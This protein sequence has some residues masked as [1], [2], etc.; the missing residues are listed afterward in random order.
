[1]RLLNEYKE[2]EFAMEKYM[3]LFDEKDYA[4]GKLD[5]VKLIIADLEK[6]VSQ[7]KKA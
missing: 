7:Y 3:D 2:S 4:L 6:L 5:E 1:M